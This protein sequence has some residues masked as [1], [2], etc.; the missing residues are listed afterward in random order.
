MNIDSRF[1]IHHIG[2]RGGNSEIKIMP[3]FEGD[4]VRVFYDA[5]ESCVN[6]IRHHTSR[7]WLTRF[8]AAD[9]PVADYRVLPYCVARRTGPVQFNLAYDPNCSS[10]L[11]MRPYFPDLTV[12]NDPPKSQDY[13]FRDAAQPIKTLSL[14][15]YALDD[16]LIGRHP[17]VPLPDILSVDVEGGES[18]VLAGAESI[19]RSVIC[20][21]GESQFTPMFEGQALYGDLHRF[22]SE[23]GFVFVRFLNTSEWA[24]YQSP[25]GLRSRGL[26]T[27]GDVIY[28]RD[29]RQLAASDLPAATKRLQLSKLAFCALMW[30]QMEIALMALGEA[31]KLPDESS[32]HERAYGRFLSD[33]AAAAAAVPKVY[34]PLFPE[35]FSVQQSHARYQTHASDQKR[36]ET[37][38]P[39]LR[40]LRNRLRLIRKKSLRK[41]L[42]QVRKVLPSKSSPIESLL[43]RNGFTELAACLKDNR[44]RM[45]VA[46][47]ARP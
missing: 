19:L 9:A 38:F 46:I 22:L 14:D 47:D 43:H 45:Q 33:V 29:P 11:P 35:R 40:R 32:L 16:L 44:L 5:D 6:Q 20:F 31:E 21:V 26:A 37:T 24:P 41:W 7:R 15:A 2:G 42:G 18:E 28:L 17:E 12:F 34:V 36:L 23:R 1:A 25:V 13:R 4:F 39:P 10:L 30:D 27:T 8:G 3:R